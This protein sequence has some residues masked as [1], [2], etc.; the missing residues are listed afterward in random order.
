MYQNKF[1][2]FIDILG[3]GALV[4]DSENAPKI[5]MPPTANA[6]TTTNINI[7]LK[8]LLHNSRVACS[9]TTQELRSN[10]KIIGYMY[11]IF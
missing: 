3:F 4:E 5:N 11:F 10:K 9:S 6:I 8:G 7:V 2:A 1:I